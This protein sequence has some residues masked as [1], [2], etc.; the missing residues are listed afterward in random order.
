MFLNGCMANN[1]AYETTKIVLTANSYIGHNYS[2]IIDPHNS[3]M[4]LEANFCSNCRLQ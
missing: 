2:F 4:A 1:V 3:L